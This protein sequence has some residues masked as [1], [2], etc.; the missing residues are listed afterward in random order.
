[1]N[2]Q[3]N[4]AII[5]SVVGK[6]STYIVQFLLLMLYA[7]IFAPDDFGVVA[8]IAVFVVFFQL[9]SDIGLGPALINE[10]KL[11]KAEWNGAFTFTCVVGVIIALI[12]SLASTP[13]G[14]YY[15]SELYGQVILVM[16]PAICFSCFCIVPNTGFVK[17]LKFSTLA[18]IDSVA[19]LFSFIMVY[20]LTDYLQDAIALASKATFFA[21]LKFV[22]LMFL[23]NKTIMKRPTLGMDL[24]VIKK[25]KR[26]AMY[27]F[28]FGM[29]NY[30]SRN[31]DNIVIAKFM[32]SHS[33]GIYDQ[34]YQLIRYP[35]QLTAFA[36]SSA[37]QPVM[38]SH[39]G[40]MKYIVEEHNKLSQKLFCLSLVIFLYINFNADLIVLI[41]LG[42][43]WKEVIIILQ[44]FNYSLPIQMLIATS[45]AFFQSIG[46]PDLLFR[47]GLIGALIFLTSILFSL[48]FFTIEAVAWSISLSFFINS[49]SIY[50][51]LYKYGF[52]TSILPFSKC[53]L[54][55][56]KKMLPYTVT[57]IALYSMMDYVF[58][59]NIYFNFLISIAVF[60]IPLALHIK[61]FI[62]VMNERGLYSSGGPL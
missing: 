48:M 51:L 47:A 32:G 27:Q 19:H 46:R 13:I 1:M 25:V 11:T 55:I 7:R 59:E 43:K 36:L 39:K 12:F 8:S 41:I 24:S 26:F 18:I 14:N 35:L 21:I 52:K 53:L 29:V 5:T 49:I 50:L 40:N 33:L 54:Y 6:L 20:F 3:L 62:S 44:I 10:E 31:S 38:T 9:I 42:E 28:S 57:A 34:A 45:G 15:E 22:L 37:I 23:S 2:K 58:F 56:I 61:P 17:E 4:R 30:F 60:L 16:S